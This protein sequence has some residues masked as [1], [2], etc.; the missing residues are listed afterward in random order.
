MTLTIPAHTHRAHRLARDIRNDTTAVLNS[1]ARAL[2]GRRFADMNACATADGDVNLHSPDGPGGLNH[3]THILDVHTGRRR[4]MTP[5]ELHRDV[6]LWTTAEVL[7]W[8]RLVGGRWI[9]PLTIFERQRQARRRLVVICWEVKTRNYG[10]GIRAARFTAQLRHSGWRAYIMT[11][12]TMAN[13]GPKLKAFKL[14]GNET[15]LQLHGA[16]N[17]PAVRAQLAIYRPWIDRL[18]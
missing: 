7:R 5:E 16:G 14:A 4:A 9:R 3:F 17:H 12:A 6:E 10:E 11:L 13:F 8:R 18:W 15:A 2:P 1:A